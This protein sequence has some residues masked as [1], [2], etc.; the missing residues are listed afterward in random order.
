MEELRRQLT[1]DLTDLLQGELRV[2]DVTTALY[3]TDASLYEIRP[4][5]VVFPKSTDDVA[6]LAAY[7]SDQQIPLIA[8]G[9]G[10]GLAGG[11]LGSG[12]VIDF[13]RY[14]NGV[15]RTGADTVRVQPGITH[16]A[17]NAFLRSCGR[18]FAPDPSTTLVTTIGGMIGVDAAGSRAFRVGS[19]RDHVQSLQTVVMGGQILEL[20]RMSARREFAIRQPVTGLPDPDLPSR[21]GRI[22]PPVR[23][24]TLKLTSL[25]PATRQHDI[26]ERLSAL[27]ADSSDLIRRH[28]PPLLRNS[29]GYMLRGVLQR[30]MLNMPRLLTGSEG[31]LGLVTEVTLHT[32]PVEEHRGTMVLM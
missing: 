23:N 11:C 32:L 15:V 21:R 4:A 27:L 14:M 12:I 17:L 9:G 5:A 6:V 29:C 26:I 13:S 8:R 2:D 25:T 10:T 16:H 31:T 28:Q 3:A 22:V 18:C 20:G 19:T 1:E 24:E 30:D 7:A